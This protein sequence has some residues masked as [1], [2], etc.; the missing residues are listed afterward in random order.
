MNSK[1]EARV[2]SRSL[3]LEEK[4]KALRQTTLHVLLRDVFS[5]VFTCKTRKNTY[6]NVSYIP[7]NVYSINRMPRHR[8]I[9]KT[10]VIGYNIIASNT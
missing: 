5:R 3:N 4:R 1:V 8:D 7:L 10:I 9:S 6:F 2:C